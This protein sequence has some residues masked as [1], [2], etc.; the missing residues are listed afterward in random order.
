[1]SPNEFFNRHV[2]FTT[3]QFAFVTEVTLE[4]ASRRLKRMV[5][6]QGVVSVTRGVWAQP[7]HP[8]YALYGVV[9]FL[10]KG[11]QGYISFLSALHIHGVISQIPSVVQIATT[12]HGRKLSTPLGRFEFFQIQPKLMRE[13]TVLHHGRVAYN[14]ATAEKAL[15]DTVYL[16]TRK[17]RRFSHFPELD[18]HA[19]N[20]KKLRTLLQNLPES[21]AKLVRA[22]ILA[23]SS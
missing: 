8:G 11:E 20:R 7:H 15:I 19:I 17:G 2:F 23:M 21:P 18:W 6:Q 4:T 14:I 9:P 5:A 22:K 10:L 1:M 16:S 13:G 12:G 3:R